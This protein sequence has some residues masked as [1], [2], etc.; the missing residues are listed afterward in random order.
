MT[1]K[2]RSTL[3]ITLLI[4]L[5]FSSVIAVTAQAEQKQQF[6]LKFSGV[7][8]PGDL[9]SQAIK[10]FAK[11][12]EDMT[13]GQITV[14]VYL[15][16][17]LFGQNAVRQ[18]IRV[19]N[20]AMTYSAPW[21]LTDEVPYM[22]M[23]TSGYLYTSYE[24]YRNV[25]G[26]PIGRAVFDDIAEKTGVRPLATFF[27]GK[28]HVNVKKSVGEVR[29]PEDLEGVKLRMPNTKSWLA[30]GRALG[31]KPA[32]VAFSELYTSLDYGTVEGQENPLKTDK[33]AK[34]YETTHY[35]VLTGHVYSDV[36]PAISEKIWDQMSPDLQAKMYKAA[37]KARAW[38]EEKVLAQQEE[39][40]EFFKDQGL[41]IIH[42][43]IEAF[44]KQVRN[45]YL[46]D[47]ELTKKWNMDLYRAVKEA[48]PEE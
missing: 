14:D 43:D 44:K 17:K 1:K 25:W 41:E 36:W 29:T 16:G 34:F 11:Y 28:R 6:N 2:L 13:D 4:G 48:A 45:F 5:V 35:I 3:I 15:Q 26:G 37:D 23:F 18:A 9:H 19:G 40:L 31:A 24:H 10:K 47:E 7:C 27:M 32:P 39:L 42:P 12:I 38:M 20:V 33:S 21:Y 30:L 8:V 22:N 46:E